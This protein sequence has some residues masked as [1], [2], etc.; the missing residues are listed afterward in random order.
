MT[1]GIT[2][3]ALPFLPAHDPLAERCDLAGDL[4]TRHDRNDTPGNP[5]VF[6]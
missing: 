4:M 2:A 5:P 3:D 6:A 1:F